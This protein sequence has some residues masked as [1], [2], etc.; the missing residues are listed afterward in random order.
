MSV[1]MLEVFNYKYDDE[2]VQEKL[3]IESRRRLTTDTVESMGVMAAANAILD[4]KLEPKDI[5]YIL[6][7]TSSPKDLS[8]STACR[9]QSWFTNSSCPAMDINA[10][11]SG[12]IYAL[13]LASTLVQRYNNILI[14]AT[15]GYSKITDFEKNSSE[16][17]GDGAAAVVVSKTPEDNFYSK[18]GTD[19]S[20]VDV[21]SCAVGGTFTMKPKEV[22]SFATEVLPR[23]ILKTLNDKMLSLGEIDYIVPHQASLKALAKTAE[24]LEFPLEKV[25]LNMKNYGNTAG[26][27]VP[28]ALYCAIKD[29]RIKHSSKLMLAAVGSGMT[30]GTAYWK[31]DYG[32]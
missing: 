17:F 27:S 25:V 31:L 16:F 1:P 20:K 32:R 26:A 29:G 12:F 11:C 15:E 10:V 28:M 18:L 14:V 2:W 19:S 24:L 9:I 7:V 6:V 3:G 21:F 5:D 23:E 8:P 22:Y 4:A 30:Y 13:D